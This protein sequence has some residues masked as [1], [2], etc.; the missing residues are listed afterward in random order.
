VVLVEGGGDLGMNV[1]VGHVFGDD[2]LL[3]PVL[4]ERGLAEDN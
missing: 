1:V 4:A 3:K 2:A